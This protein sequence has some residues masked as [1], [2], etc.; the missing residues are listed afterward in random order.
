MTE[1]DLLS[2]GRVINRRYSMRIL[3]RLLFALFVWATV[4]SCTSGSVSVEGS[5]QDDDPVV[6][7]FPIAY[8]KRPIPVELD[9]NDIEQPAEDILREPVNFFPGANLFIRDRATPSATETNIT[10]AL[11]EEG[12]LFDVKDVDVSYDGTKLVFAVRAPEIEDADEEDQPTWNIWEYDRATQLI[13]R[14]ISSDISAEEGQDISPHYL[15]DGRIV[16]TST[17]QRLAKAILLDEGKPQFDAFDEDQ[18]V[19][20]LALHVMN[21]DGTQVKQITFNQ[22]HDLAPSVLTNGKIVFSRWD[23]AANNDGISLYQINP[24]G[25]GLEFL[26]G[27]HSHDTGT[28]GGRIEFMQARQG[29]DGRILIKLRPESS[30]RLG[31]ELSFIDWENFTEINQTTD[32]ATGTT[33]PAQMSATPFSVRTDDEPSIGGRFA[34]VYPLFDGSGRFL[35]SWTPCRLNDVDAQNNPIIVPC[36]QEAIDLDG[37]E[38]ALPLYGIWSF[39]PAE[40][41]QIPIVVGV[42]GIVVHEIVAMSPRDLGVVIPDSEPTADTN[43]VTENV[44]VVHIESVYDFDGVDVSPLG[45]SAMADPLQATA[46]NRPAR[47]I[48]VVKAV[49]L[50]DEDLVDLDNTAFGRN[51]AQQMKDILGYAVVEPDGSAMFKVPANVA[52]ALSVLDANGR[53]I[54]ERHQNWMTVKAGEIK[55]C[56]GCHSSNS[57]LPHGRYDAEPASPNL[58]APATGAPFPNTNPALFADLGETM[59]QVNNRINGFQSLSVNI[60]YTDYWTDPALSVP[61]PDINYNYSDLSSPAPTTTG[62]QTN[63]TALCRISINYVDE[64]QPIWDVSRQV[65]D[66]MGNLVTDNTCIVCHNGSDEMGVAQ[67]PAAQLELVGDVSADEPDH[68]VSYRELMFGDNAVEVINGALID[69]LVPVFDANGNPV[70]EVDENGNLILD[71]NGDPIPVTQTVPVTPSLDVSAANNSDRFFSVFMAGGTH[72]GR[73]NEAELK[74]LSEWLDIGGQYYNNPFDV[75]QN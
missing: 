75:P 42:E 33:G 8:V 71:A 22:S 38:E 7:D 30:T 52:F 43:L 6:V 24:D 9:N 12:A 23:N 25:T 47:F 21:A 3:S 69:L 32:D 54:T 51:R 56:H 19:A 72:S 16:F 37:S 13:R 70:F 1:S 44:G 27:Y 26:Y 68:L 4:S 20:T 28:D 17:R 29:P 57:E 34:N 15:P 48:R 67:V 5:G 55:K 45:I 60:N 65:F 74:L 61:N 18:N 36:T 31:G 40:G 39:D 49:S 2:I 11:F 35:I 64:I 58:G 53:R 14:I 46:A 66:A 10:E 62:C 73:L 50:P 59:A 63:W 41:T